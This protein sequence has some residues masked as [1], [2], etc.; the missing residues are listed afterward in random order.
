MAHPRTDTTSWSLTRRGFLRGLALAGGAGLLAA[1]VAPAVT[2]TAPVAIT[3]ASTASAARTPPPVAATAAATPVGAA[4]ASMRM[5]CW[6]QPLAEQANIYAAQEFGWFDE[7]RID[8]TFVPG[9]GGGDALKHILAGNADIAFANVEPLFFALQEGA[10]LRAIYNI[11]PQN[12]FNVVALKSSGITSI[13]DLKG[14]RVGVYS[15]SSGTRYNLMVLL[16]SVGLSE[17]DVEVVAAGIANFG[18]LKEGQVQATAAT[19]TG[20]YAAEQAGLGETTVFWA[21]DV[22]NTPSDVFIVTEDVYQQRRED[23][24]RFLR[25]YRKGSQWMLAHPADAAGI[26]VKYATDGADVA[27]AT[28]II[29]LRNASTVSPTT[30]EKGLGTFDLDVLAKVAATFHELGIIREAIDTSA[31]FTNELVSAL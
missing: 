14:K 12:V 25:A 9:A 4:R 1:C 16:R 26:A 11:Y 17:S 8:F 7:E 29:T 10:K 18:P 28:G 19:D 23:S 6:S 5:A 3:P 13:A 2:P 20:L 30:T 27:R 22:L 15:Q 31:V 21:R 24:I